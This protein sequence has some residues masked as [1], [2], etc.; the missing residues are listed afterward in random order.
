MKEQLAV[1][2]ISAHKECC[3]KPDEKDTAL[4]LPLSTFDAPCN[5]PCCIIFLI[6]FK[7]RIRTFKFLIIGI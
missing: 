2:K 4:N 1:S 6:N 3:V 7:L 5:S